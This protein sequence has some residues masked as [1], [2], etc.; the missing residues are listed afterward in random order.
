MNTAPQRAGFSLLEVMCAVF[1]LGVAV[2]GMA[3]GIATALRSSQ[4]AELE[5]RS[6]LLA[7][8]R[9]ETLRAEGLLI[10][11]ESTGS[12]DQDLAAYRWTE[13]IDETDI[14][15][16]YQVVVTVRHSESE[17][18]VY[19]LRTLLFDPPLQESRPLEDA[20]YPERRNTRKSPAG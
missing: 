19:E 20:A 3:H 8:G 10:E 14:E 5:T 7:A 2:A 15:G 4:E 16:L 12:G 13:T 11:G 18:F 6:A 17:R 9:I 1:I